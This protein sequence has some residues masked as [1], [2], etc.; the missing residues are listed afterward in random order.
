M[1]DNNQARA[2]SIFMEAIEKPEAERAAFVRDACNGDDALI[3]EVHSLLASHARAGGFLGNATAGGAAPTQE[4]CSDPLR[5][6]PGTMIGPYKLLQLIGEGGFGSV[7]VAEQE[8]PVRRKV[9]L[10]IIKLGMHTKQVIARFEAERQ[11]LAIMD[12]PNIAKVFDAGATDTGRPYFVMELV[13][14]VPITDYCDTNNLPLPERLV[15]FVS[16]CQAVQHAHSKGIIHRDLK[17]N[18]VMVTLADGTPA[19]KVIDF[20]I[21]K[22]TDQRLTERTLFT[23]FRQMIGTPA[24]MSPEQADMAG[25]DIDTRSDVYSLGVLLY[26]LLV[27]S[28]PFDPQELRSKAYAEMQR[29]IREVEPPRPS[30]RLSSLGATLSDVAMHRRIDPAQLARNMKGELD[31]IVMKALEKDRTRRY[32]TANG[33]AM[34]VRRYLS[35][36]TV[37]ACPPSVG[38]RLGKLAR[39][40][41]G[42]L[43]AAVAGV[44]LL[45]G[46]TGFSAWQAVRAT[47]AEVRARAD[48]DRVTVERDRATRAE[49]NAR[50]DRDRVAVEKQRADREAAIARAVNSFLDHDLLEQASPL[51]QHARASEAGALTEAPTAPDPR[52]TVREALDN[53]AARITSR[54]KDQPRIEFAIRVTMGNAYRDVAAYAQA[55]A[56][57]QAALSLARRTWGDNDEDTLMCEGNLARLEEAQWH[58]GEAETLF[59]RS[60]GGARKQFGDDNEGVLSEMNFLGAM[61]C[62]RLARYADAERIFNQV[63]TGWRKIQ[64]NAGPATLMAMDN[65]AEV[66]EKQGRLAEAE[67]LHKQALETSRKALGETHPSTLHFLRNLAA[68][69][70]EEE[71]LGDAEQLFNQALEGS[72]KEFGEGHPETLDAVE[73]LAGVYRKEKRLTD[74]KRLFERSFEGRRKALGDAHPDTINA[75]NNLAGIYH[76]EGRRADAERLFQQALQ[77]AR[78]ALGE[79]HPLILHLLAIRAD[80]YFDDHRYADAQQLFAQVLEGDRKA[81][82][83][84]HPATLTTMTNLAA[85]YEYSGRHA[86]AERLYK[87]GLEAQRKVLGDAHPNTLHTSFWLAKL[88]FDEGRYADAEAL[89]E[90]EMKGCRE[91]LGEAHPHTLRAMNNLASTY[92]KHG[93][94]A[95]AERLFEQTLEGERK[96]LGDAH[97]DTLRTM[98]GLAAACEHAHDYPRAEALGLEWLRLARTHPGPAETAIEYVADSLLVRVYRTM[99]NEQELSKYLRQT[100]ETLSATA[101]ERTKDLASTQLTPDARAKLLERRGILL[102]RTGKFAV[103]AADLQKSIELN[104]LNHWPWYYRGCILAYL[105]NADDAYSDNCS[106]MLDRFA[107]SGDWAAV[108]RTI[109]SSLLSPAPQNL[110]RLAEL[111]RNYLAA[112]KLAGHDLSYPELCQ[113]LACYRLGDYAGALEAAEACN[114]RL[115]DVRFQVA[116]RSI[117]AMALERQDRHNE[118]VDVL[119][120]AL[121][122]AGLLP[123]PG[124]EDLSEDPED[125]LICQVLLREA[126]RTVVPLPASTQA[127]LH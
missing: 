6:G 118:A 15:L 17:P 98:H 39:R 16:V 62:D 47:R 3:Q 105:E 96:V 57:L 22:A 123:K 85:A 89:F 67:A 41:K 29:M 52:L 122:V 121:A 72:R 4:Q 91:V 63:L 26:E 77:D 37:E 120:R 36:E 110:K 38:Y 24:Y 20:G 94:H 68:Q 2:L 56:Q 97:P 55:N 8:K 84:S 127:A 108:D 27:G 86:D 10:K 90:Q 32:E 44:L 53:A 114:A 19:P 111:A 58:F 73:R 28:T 116:A 59:L 66:Y 106:G 12:H 126:S 70:E 92:E 34:D 54:F 124:Q 88:Y 93:R 103:A 81:L 107:T 60:L 101:A 75:M 1:S 48:R 82:G 5:E 23:E 113:S 109:K 61:Y 35:D 40:Y 102:A 21:A 87:Q 31:W 80:C 104:P 78:K 79:T 13:R 83:D 74:A 11:A 119:Q 25:I 125:W 71:R 7:F 100:L 42:P 99:G 14:G 45:L 46:A 117:I 49:A 50:A 112:E 95:D 30:T 76:L 43:R 9:A 115:H 64:G 18:N 69:Y 51:N 33:L 65:L